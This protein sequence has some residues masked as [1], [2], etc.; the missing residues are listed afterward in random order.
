M[1]LR[2]IH[3]FVM[4]KYVEDVKQNEKNVPD[5]VE[6]IVRPTGLAKEELRMI[7]MKIIQFRPKFP[8]FRVCTFQMPGKMTDFRRR[9][10][11][12]AK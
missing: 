11:A 10:S 3:F 4:E 5:L 8:E 7:L 6:S 12:G 9:L 2:T 1:T